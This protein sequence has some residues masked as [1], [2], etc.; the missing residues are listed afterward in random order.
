[1]DGA[2]PDRIGAGWAFPARVDS[3]GNVCL[4]GGDRQIEQSIRLIL[5]TAPGE[6]LMRPDFG[7]AIHDLVFAPADVATAGRVAYEVRRSIERWEPRVVLHDVAVDFAD[8]AS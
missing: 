7:C 1:M 2:P 5:G 6:R 8:A 4:A 3:L